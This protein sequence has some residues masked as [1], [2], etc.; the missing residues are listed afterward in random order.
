MLQRAKQLGIILKIMKEN[1]MAHPFCYDIQFTSSTSFEGNCAG[2]TCVFFNYLKIH[3]SKSVHTCVC[4]CMCG[5]QL[6]EFY[7]KF[8]L[9]L[10]F[11]CNPQRDFM[12]LI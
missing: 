9:L 7:K 4:L 2:S 1:V 5:C 10:P 6:G 3:A 11:T 12:Y 8:Y